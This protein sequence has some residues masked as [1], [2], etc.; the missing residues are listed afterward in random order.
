[1]KIILLIIVFCLSITGLSF[2]QSLS[3]LKL[4]DNNKKT[5]VNP[6][7]EAG[8]YDYKKQL[9]DQIFVT[10]SSIQNLGNFKNYYSNGSGVMINYGMYFPNSWLAVVRTGYFNEPLKVGVDSGGFNNFNYIP[11]HFGGRFYV[12]KNVFMPY[13]SFMNGINII[14]ASDFAGDSNHDDET[15]VKYAFQV[16]FGFDVKFTKN[17]G[18]NASINFNNSFWEDADPGI[19]QEGK[20]MTG[21]EYSGGLVYNFNR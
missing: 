8:S 1:M 21:F 17:F 20:M 4:S 14:S 13:F 3:P 19:G 2:S 15:T 12:Y 5:I 9:S 18:I 6:V 16:G 7:K 10:Y 11:I